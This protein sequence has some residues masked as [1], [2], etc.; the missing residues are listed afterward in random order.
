[1][2]ATRT[3]TRLQTLPLI[4]PRRAPA[5]VGKAGADAMSEGL[6]RA[7]AHLEDREWSRAFEALV[8]LADAGE[9]EAARLALLMRAHGS[10]L[11]GHAFPVSPAQRA[12]WVELSS[13]PFQGG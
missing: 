12:R 9:C 8:P 3:S 10:R 13:K 2:H 1:M 6:G 4:G 5:A 7:L 11:F